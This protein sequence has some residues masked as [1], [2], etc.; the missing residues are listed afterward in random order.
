MSSMMYLVNTRLDI[1]FVVNVLIQFYLEPCH[2]HWIASKHILRYLH[3]TI[4]HC[5]KYDGKEVKLTSFTYSDWGGSET[6]RRSTNSGYFSLGSAMIS[7]MNR[8]QGLVALSGAQEEYVVACE[9]GK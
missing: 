7:W 2:D 6:D 1:H 3:G 5:L 9:V 4:H 8:K